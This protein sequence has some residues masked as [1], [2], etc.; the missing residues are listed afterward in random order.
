M[1][2]LVV[3]LMLAGFILLTGAS[4]ASAIRATGSGLLDSTRMMRTLG[5]RRAP[6]RASRRAAAAHEGEDEGPGRYPL[7][8]PEPGPEQ[9]IVRATHVEAPSQN[10]WMD[11]EEPAGGPGERASAERA[12]VPEPEPRERAGEPAEQEEQGIAGAIQDRPARADAAA[13]TPQGQAPRRGHR[14]PGLPVGAAARG[15]AADALKRRADAPR[16]R[17]AGAHRNAPGGGARA[18]RRAGQGDRHRRRA[19]HHAL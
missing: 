10:D 1:D 14:G 18:L 6:P 8:P 13:L 12:P 15:G 9:L 3:F 11:A 17:R 16:H 2:I 5:E 4:L 7:S 19:A